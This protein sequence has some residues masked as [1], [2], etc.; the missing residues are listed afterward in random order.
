MADTSQDKKDGSWA[1][2]P[3]PSTSQPPRGSKLGA[4]LAA[5]LVAGL[6]AFLAWRNFSQGPAPQAAP[7]PPPPQAVA[8]AGPS[9][10]EPASAPERLGDQERA[11]LDAI[12]DKP[13]FRSWLDQGDVLNRWALAIANLAEG[14]VPRKALAFLAPAQP[15]SVTRIGGEE[16]VS[17]A[18]Y[19]RFD[20]IGDVLASLDPALLATAYRG[21]H[22]PLE[23]AYRALGDPQGSLDVAADKALD[24]L[25]R[26]PVL[27]RAPAV[28]PA[29]E[30]GLLLF[31]DP[32]L[33]ALGQL[34]KQVLRLGPRNGRLIKNKAAAIRRVLDLPR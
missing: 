12:S 9:G 22:R 4:G 34:E 21:L 16:V 23:A 24:R 25:A 8:A 30:G 11:L 20:L 33:E 29:A 1:G 28:I 14:V 3:P 19:R 10:P 31:K 6:A 17:E 2:A 27:D 5:V 15:F 18:A 32:K 26:A 13:A 7:S